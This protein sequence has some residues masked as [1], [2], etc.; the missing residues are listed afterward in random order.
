VTTQSFKGGKGVRKF[1]HINAKGGEG[2]SEAPKGKRRAT[3]PYG[4]GGEKGW[5]KKDAP[6]SIPRV[7]KGKKKAKQK[8]RKKTLQQKS[9]QSKKRRKKRK[10]KAEEVASPARGRVWGRLLS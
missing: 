2:R 4:G 5:K 6:G 7:V 3:G 8:I 9:S 10:N 1:A